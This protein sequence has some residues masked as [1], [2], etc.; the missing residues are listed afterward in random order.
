MPVGWNDTFGIGTDFSAAAT[1]NMFVDAVNERFDYPGGPAGFPIAN[2]SAGDDFQDPSFIAALQNA[3]SNNIA[4][5]VVPNASADG[6]AWNGVEVNPGLPQWTWAAYKTAYLGGNEWTRKYPREF[7]VA[8]ST[9]YTDGSA[10]ANG[11]V[12]RNI[13]DGKVYTRTAGAWVVTPGALPDV[14]TAHGVAQAG[15]YIGA[16]LF[17]ELRDALNRIVW[18]ITGAATTDCSGTLYDGSATQSTFAGAKT[19]ADANY[20][21]GAGFATTNFYAAAYSTAEASTVPNYTVE[22]QAAFTAYNHVYGVGPAQAGYV[23][24]SQFDF[25]V[26]MD[27]PDGT[28][29]SFDDNGDG[30]SYRVWKKYGSVAQG[31]AASVVGAT[32]GHAKSPEP[33]W[34]AA[35]TPGG[36]Q[37]TRGYQ[38]IYLGRGANAVVQRMDVAGAFTY[39]P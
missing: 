28:S 8:A 31:G 3:V 21:S 39:R 4:L 33:N 25:Y 37:L 26:V 12:A 34:C 35:P 9:N 2:V 10:F 1:F 19:S 6:R 17:T 30:F 36:A 13:D 38:S 15:D 27:S 29:G 16:W 7:A 22:V 32:V 5:Y 23:D 14:V 18:M 20:A 24:H 11:H